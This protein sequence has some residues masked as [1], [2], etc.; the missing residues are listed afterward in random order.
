MR[1]IIL[2]NA[3]NTVRVEIK[4]DIF[5]TDADLMTAGFDTRFTNM[6]LDGY[7]DAAKKLM[8]IKEIESGWQA[9]RAL[10]TATSGVGLYYISEA[11]GEVEVVAP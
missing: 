10:A 7:D 5:A 9:I 4:C 8:N 2:R 6:T 11:S 3:A 1:N